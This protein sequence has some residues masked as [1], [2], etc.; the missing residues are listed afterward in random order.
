MLRRGARPVTAGEAPLLPQGAPGMTPRASGS[1]GP[2]PDP[3]NHGA[4]R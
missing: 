1:G 2:P 3:G 4:H